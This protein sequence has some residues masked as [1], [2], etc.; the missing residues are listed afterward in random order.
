MCLQLRNAACYTA[1]LSAS[2]TLAAAIVADIVT[3]NQAQQT[4]QLTHHC[5]LQMLVKPAGKVLNYRTEVTGATDATMQVCHCRISAIY[6]RFAAVQQA[7]VEG[8]VAD[9][10]KV[11]K[12]AADCLTSRMG[13]PQPTNPC[14]V[15]SLVC[16]NNFFASGNQFSASIYT[17]INVKAALQSKAQNSSGEQSSCHAGRAVHQ[18]GC[19]RSYAEADAGQRGAGGA[20]PAS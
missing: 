19:T 5:P 20:C 4:K 9:I 6:S 2:S 12:Q 7:H 14:A 16:W 17:N 10:L 18:A 13:L 15:L 8:F 11:D 3:G 1:N